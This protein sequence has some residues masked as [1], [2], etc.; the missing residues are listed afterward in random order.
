MDLWSVGCILAEMLTKAPLFNCPS[1]ITQLEKMLQVTGRPS[2]EEIDELGSQAATVI[3]Q[4]SIKPKTPKE[5]F[6]ATF[7]ESCL[8]L[9][10]NL[11][12]FSSNKRFS[13]EQAL[14]HPYLKDFFRESDLLSF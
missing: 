11:L 4:C 6:G 12:R 3:R 13:A 7:D 5:L 2:W 9:L 1:T 10:L 14:R 8:D